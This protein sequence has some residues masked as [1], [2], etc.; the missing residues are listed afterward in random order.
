VARRGVDASKRLATVSR[1]GAA[2]RRVSSNRSP[3]FVQGFWR[4]VHVYLFQLPRV[5]GVVDA[6]AATAPHEFVPL[7]LLGG[8]ATPAAAERRM[9][10]GHDGP[11]RLDTAINWY[12]AN[13]RWSSIRVPESTK[14]VLC[15]NLYVWIDQDTALMPK[16][17]H[18]TAR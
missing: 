8:R 2:S 11:L 13:V 7:C 16:A 12:A 1:Y 17:A 15:A 5:A 18:N 14:K 9:C 6:A 10:T 3:P 4:L